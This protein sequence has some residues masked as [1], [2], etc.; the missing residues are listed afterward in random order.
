MGKKKHKAKKNKKVPIV[1]EA[2]SSHKECLDYL[3]TVST[4]Q[5][6]CNS[7]WHAITCQ[8][9]EKSINK[10]S[11]RKLVL[12]LD[13][14]VADTKNRILSLTQAHCTHDERVEIKKEAKLKLLQVR[15]KIKEELGLKRPYEEDDDGKRSGGEDYYDY[16]DGEEVVGPYESLLNDDEDEYDDDQEES[17]WGYE[18][19]GSSWDYVEHDR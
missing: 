7:L 12:L 19:N 16:D 10:K 18:W 5:D 6:C 1:R 17:R 4:L 9:D 2:Y 8:L 15:S 13:Y 14:V 11:L 3:V